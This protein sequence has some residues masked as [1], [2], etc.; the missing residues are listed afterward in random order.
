MATED[1]I[2]EVPRAD[3]G[4]LLVDPGTFDPNKKSLG[5][6]L[7]RLRKG[8]STPG[9][10][11]NS[12]GCAGKARKVNSAFTRTAPLRLLAD[13][14]LPWSSMNFG[15]LGVSPRMALSLHG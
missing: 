6:P 5:R 3:A 10:L 14:S 15:D 7:A 9:E 2:E 11:L 8:H 1:D 4:P 12:G 13:S